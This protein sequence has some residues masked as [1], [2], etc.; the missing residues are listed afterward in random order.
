MVTKAL[1][2]GND[3]TF[4]NLI[5]TTLKITGD[6]D[7]HVGSD[8][9]GGGIDIIMHQGKITSDGHPLT[10]SSDTDT[11]ELDTPMRLDLPEDMK[12]KAIFSK[13]NQLDTKNQLK[14]VNNN[15]IA[16]S[17]VIITPN[18]DPKCRYWVVPSEGSFTIHRN[19]NSEF[20][21]QYLIIN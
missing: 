11:I 15:C 16:N 9:P 7:W 21:F 13:N 12:G 17:V 6:Q 10:L 8:M 20:K 19:T 3:S 5:C 4:D 1:T 2:E 18:Q 14:I